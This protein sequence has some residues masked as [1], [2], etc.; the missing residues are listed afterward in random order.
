[1]L[2]PSARSFRLPDFARLLAAS[3]GEVKVVQA[4]VR[5]ASAKTTL[6]TSGTRGPQSDDSTPAA[7]KLIAAR[8]EGLAYSL[9]ANCCSA[10]GR[11]GA[12]AVTQHPPNFMIPW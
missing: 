3:R 8:A 11:Q 10:N 6:D 5:H 12:L 9:R 7:I 1:M 2:A 4:G